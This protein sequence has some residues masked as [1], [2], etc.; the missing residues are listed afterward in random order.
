MTGGLLDPLRASS[1]TAIDSWLDGAEA[2]GSR[3]V[4]IILRSADPEDLTLR[5][6][7][8]LGSADIIAYEPS[9]PAAILDRARADALRRELVAGSV[10]AAPG[11]VLVVRGA[12]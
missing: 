6:A 3:M 5:E 12:A 7:R 9:V 8:L 2:D 11:L 10:A 1:A 4:E